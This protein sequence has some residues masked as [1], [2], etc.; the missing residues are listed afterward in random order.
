MIKSD[1]DFLERTINVQIYR[2]LKTRNPYILREVRLIPCEMDLILLE[3]N[4]LKLIAFEIKR[5]KWNELLYQT[6]RAKLYCHYSFAVMPYSKRGSI[7]IESFVEK[8]VGIIFYKKNGR[9]LDLVYENQPQHS[10]IINRILKQQ[11]YF[12]FYNKYGDLI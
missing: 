9:K 7:P 10:L 5:N 6:I 2:L 8:G 3:P 12:Q 11:V 4:S 1:E